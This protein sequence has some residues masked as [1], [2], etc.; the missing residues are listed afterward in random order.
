MDSASLGTSALHLAVFG[1]VQSHLVAGV[2]LVDCFNDID[3]SVAGPVTRVGHPDSGPGS[4]AI[5]GVL[6]IEN[7]ETRVELL[8]G[9]DTHRVAAVLCIGVLRVCS[10]ECRRVASIGQVGGYGSGLVHVAAFMLVSVLGIACRW[11]ANLTKPLA[12]SGEEW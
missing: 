9:G 3:L 2:A 11:G 7:E 12:G 10:E 8:L 1:S 4:A 5:R 6:D